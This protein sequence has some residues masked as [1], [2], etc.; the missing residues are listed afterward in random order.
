MSES[1]QLVLYRNGQPIDLNEHPS[2]LA[3]L[4]AS[5][6]AIK[7]IDERIHEI[8]AEV[9]EL[10]EREQLHKD[11][12]LSV[13]AVRAMI[14]RRNGEMEQLLR[15]RAAHEKNY[16][17]VPDM[18]G[19]WLPLGEDA[20]RMRFNPIDTS[21]PLDVLRALKHAKDSGIFDDFRVYEPARTSTD[22]MIVGLAGGAAFYIASWR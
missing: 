11:L 17:E 14:T 13:K 7:G 4:H 19:R 2:L 18:G 22:P 10:Q 8:G 9:A 21:V 5:D 20:E 15:R 6:R 12:G 16:L 3:S 1:T